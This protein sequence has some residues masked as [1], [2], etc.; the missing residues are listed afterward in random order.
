[1]CN[2]SAAGSSS[3]FAAREVVGHLGI[4]LLDGLLLGAG[5]A[6]T[7]ALSFATG[8]AT[9]TSGTG[10]SLL[11]GGRLRLV[12]LRLTENLLVAGYTARNFWYVRYTIGERRWA[13]G[14]GKGGGADEHL[15]ANRAA[16]N[17]DAIEVGGGLGGLVMLLEDDGSAPNAAALGVVLE[18]NLLRATYTNSIHKVV[19]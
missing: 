16:V 14:G 4:E 7:T 3:G 12:L 9:S 13:S 18:K 11:S 8:L 15:D 10:S 6:T 17:L 2:L 5:L 1:M 19:L